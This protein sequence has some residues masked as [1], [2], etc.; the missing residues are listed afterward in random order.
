M[1]KLKLPLSES[2]VPYVLM[3]NLPQTIISFLYL[4]YNG[5]FTCMLAG[6]EWA[7]YSIKRAPLRVTIPRPG[8]RSTHFLQLPYTWGAPLLISS[9]LLHWFISQSIFLI[10]IAVYKNGVPI[11]A[12]TE[13]TT[14]KYETYDSY[15]QSGH[16]F[17]GVGYSDVGLITSI[18]WGTG[19]VIISLLVAGIYTYPKGIPIGGT[20]SAVIS[21][22][23][24]LRNETDG[25]EQGEEEVTEKPL[26]WGVTIPGEMDKPGHCCF[27][28][29]D[30]QAPRAGYLYAGVVRE[31]W[32]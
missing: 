11:S 32:D 2:I 18:C 23:C 20:N 15:S 28:D 4:T 7:L 30:V 31:K 16:V 12:S 25:E 17:T 10:R 14:L 19:L 21:A 3:A 5:L 26:M 13:F 29:K 27:T 24:H 8:Q 9:I 1:I 22:A 6:R